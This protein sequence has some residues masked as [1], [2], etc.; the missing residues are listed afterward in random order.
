MT[1]GNGIARDRDRQ[2]RAVDACSTHAH[3]T[4]E[5]RA[6][7][8][9]GESL[10][11]E[12]AYRD[13]STAPPTDRPLAAQRMNLA[14]TLFL[15]LQRHGVS[16]LRF[17]EMIGVNEKAVRKMLDGRSPI[18]MATLGVI[19]VDMA[20]DFMESVISG[21]GGATP[22]PPMARAVDAL[23]RSRDLKAVLEGQRALLDLAG[24]LSR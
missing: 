4:T 21:R 23:R 9:T 13:W 16:R 22:P 3:G 19:P 8:R 5:I 24:E 15:V 17:A 12:S 14:K 11:A 1:K 18:P 10:T 7:Q 20:L 6:E 2:P